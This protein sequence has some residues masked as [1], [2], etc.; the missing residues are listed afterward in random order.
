MTFSDRQPAG[1]P[2]RPSWE[3]A[4][5]PVDAKDAGAP[6]PVQPPAEPT[7]SARR[8]RRKQTSFW[9][10]LPF[11]I[12]V[13]LVLALLI[14][15]F[16]V[17]AFYI[18]SGSMEQTL[19][20]GDRVLVNKLVYRFRSPHR[21]EII[22]FKG[23]PDWAAEIPLS[24]PS[25]PVVRFFSDIGQVVG[26]APSN[27]RDFIKRVIGL[28]GDVVACCTAAHQI[29]VNGHPLHEPYIYL[30]GPNP[31][32][33]AWVPFHVKVPPGHLWV[34]G[35]HR[36]DSADSRAHDTD[37]ASGTIPISDVI[38]RAFVIV[39]PPSHWRFLSVPATF[40]GRSL[41]AGAPFGLASAVVVPIGLVRRRRRRKRR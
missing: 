35:D 28:P 9:K 34:M 26:I 19:R 24:V 33:L 11:L 40:T 38:G 6:A 14:K 4:G 37:A 16:L 3:P 29:T 7:A 10:E 12:A 39:W 5:A 18:P 30:G 17:Q 20:I 31:P 27:N 22:V 15:T 36:N 8:S 2:A 41:A 23:P 21:G 13:A 1:E 25:N 32:S